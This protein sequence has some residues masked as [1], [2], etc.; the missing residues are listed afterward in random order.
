MFQCQLRCGGRVLLLHIFPGTHLHTS[1]IL[2]I[3]VDVCDNT[4]ILV[5]SVH[6]QIP[7]STTILHRT[8][9]THAILRAVVILTPISLAWFKVG[10]FSRRLP[11]HFSTSL[12]GVSPTWLFRSS[13][14][15]VSS[16]HLGNPVLF[17]HLL[18][19]VWNDLQ[20]W[21]H[22]RSSGALRHHQ[23]LQSPI[24]WL[25]RGRLRHLRLKHEWCL[26]WKIG[27]RYRYCDAETS[28]LCC[29]CNSP[30]LHT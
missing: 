2:L 12:C 17:R 4:D 6:T 23:R 5:P 9:Q 8:M 1:F 10:E 25:S 3:L 15:T 26:I 19:V 30:A 21:A 14:L 24:F 13:P 22:A 27:T 11:H 29:R 16:G 7:P 28:Q 20:L 18:L